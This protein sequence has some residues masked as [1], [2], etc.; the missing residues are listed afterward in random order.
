M[1]L[2]MEL[3]DVMTDYVIIQCLKEDVIRH[4]TLFPDLKLVGNLLAVLE[5]YMS[6]HDY[7]SFLDRIEEEYIK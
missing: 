7:Q 3:D 5:Y 4:L 6:Y 1:R 2:K